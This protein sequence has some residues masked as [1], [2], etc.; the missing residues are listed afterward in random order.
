LESIP[1]LHKRLKIRALCTTACS[2]SITRI[3][4]ENRDMFHMSKGQAKTII[5]EKN[6]VSSASLEF[7][8]NLWGIG[9][10]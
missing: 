9:T 5:A 7:Y 10:E 1:G 8:N 3:R 6:T 4:N 2:F